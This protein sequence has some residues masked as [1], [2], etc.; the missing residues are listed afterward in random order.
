MQA[1]AENGP[2][3]PILLRIEPQAGHGA[4]KPVSKQVEEWADIMTFLFWQTGL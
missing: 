4:G 3:R 1:S 2:E